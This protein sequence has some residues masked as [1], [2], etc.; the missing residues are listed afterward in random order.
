MHRFRIV[1]AGC[2]NMAPTWLRHTLKRPDCAVV[3]LVD[4]DLARARQLKQ[5]FH[6][7][8]PQFPS[9]GCALQETP[10]NLVYDLTVPGSH[11]EIVTEALSRQCDVLGEKPMADSLANA[12]RMLQAARDSGRRYFVMQNRRYTPGMI[13]LRGLLDSGIIGGLDY[14]S[15]D[16]FIG[17]HFGGFRDA[18]DDPLL[19][20]MAI[21]TFDQA[22]FLS[23]CDSTAVTSFTYNPKSSWYRGN[24][25]AECIFELTGRVIFRYS[26]SWCAEG[27]STSW[28]SA[29]RLTGSAGT[30]L[31]DGT[32]APVIETVKPAPAQNFLN[33]FE[34]RELEVPVLPEEGHG[35]ALSE[36]FTALSGG[37]C[38]QTSCYDNIKSLGMVFAARES[39]KRGQRVLLDGL[40]A[41][42][43][44][45]RP[46]A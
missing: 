16:F 27:F 22:R 15:A 12:S 8:C 23:G 24:A 20:D 21:H 34:R 4:I 10:A 14:L 9:L 25:A 19:L 17:A 2:G 44:Q 36:M 29:W 39:A 46:T 38:S 30:I 45:P 13:A 1:I 37:G 28:E 41:P 32:H 26:G 6:L 35:A 42:D 7:D 40:I 43:R 33:E 18:M 11:V 31:W 3:G 5:A